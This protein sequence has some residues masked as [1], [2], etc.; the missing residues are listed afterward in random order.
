M[1]MSPARE[2][3]SPLSLSSDDILRLLPH[4]HPF[5][6]LDRV[7]SVVPG[8]WAEAV[9]NVTVSDGF[10][11]GHFPGR[12][13][14]P[15][16]LLVECV[17]QLAAVVYGTQASLKATEVPV[18]D[19]AHRVGYLAEIKQAKFL[20]IVVP[21]DQLLVKVRSGPRRGELI[22]VSG[23]VSVGPR[24]VMTAKLTVT[25]RADDDPPTF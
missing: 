11:S 8:E 12:S 21:G 1:T 14:Y 19:V 4:R 10:L 5:A 7:T 22:C 3:V 25:Q 2:Q 23:Q 9:K 16:V 24:V 6:L 18:A 15:G 17:A 13:I 20:G